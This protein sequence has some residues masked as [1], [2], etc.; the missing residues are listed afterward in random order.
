MRMTQIVKSRLATQQERIRDLH[1]DRDAWKACAEQLR[2]ALESNVTRL[3]T[4]LARELRET[5]NPVEDVGAMDS[6]RATAKAVSTFNHLAATFRV[7]E[8]PR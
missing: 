7:R 4:A 1:K 5:S 6:M 3:Q 8:E 2:F